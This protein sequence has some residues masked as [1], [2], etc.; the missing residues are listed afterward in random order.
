M[1]KLL[2]LKNQ[3]N[4]NGIKAE[5]QTAC[6]GNYFDGTQRGYYYDVLRIEYTPGT[7]ETIDKLARRK[8][9]KLTYYNIYSEVA[10]AATNSDAENAENAT[11]AANIF[12]DAFFLALHVGKSQEIALAEGRAALANR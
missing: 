12:L 2:A 10:I 11:K 9:C 6:A 5:I 1:N 7:L 4:N 3:L 8:G